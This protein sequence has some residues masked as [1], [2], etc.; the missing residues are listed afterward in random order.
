M[1]SYYFDTTKGTG[2]QSIQTWRTLGIW[3]DH[4]ANAMHVISDKTDSC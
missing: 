1:T 2:C 4:A 3:T